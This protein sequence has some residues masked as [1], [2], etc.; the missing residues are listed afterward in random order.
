MIL[1]A[2]EIWQNAIN[3]LVGDALAEAVTALRSIEPSFDD[4]VLADWPAESCPTCGSL[5]L[6]QSA[7]GD[8][9]CLARDPP[10]V[11]RRIAEVA[12]QIK[13]QYYGASDAL[14]LAPDAIC[15][16]GSTTWRDVPIHD[17]NAIRRDCGRCGR[18]L[19][20]PVWD[21]SEFPLH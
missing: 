10:T 20:F 17:G 3:R 18:F 8:W 19:D 2:R 7:M 4:D 21:G 1:H 14:M 15:P 5:E 12:Q 16:C 9:R 13:Q 6:W 11:S